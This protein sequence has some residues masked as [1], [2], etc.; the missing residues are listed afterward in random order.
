[1]P[2]EP[3]LS[4]R[5]TLF[6]FASNELYKHISKLGDRLNQVKAI[7]DWESFRPILSNLYNNRTDKGGRPN[8]DEI[9]MLKVIV[10]Q[11]WYNL[12]DQEMEFQLADRI[13]FHHFIGSSDIPDFST[14]WRF[15][16]R[17]NKSGV[18]ISCME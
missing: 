2:I 12:S 18:W 13:S 15:R 8:I 16:E 17:L 6:N 9:I 7:I 5:E 4:M 3:Y 11:N 1:M 10:L 14:I